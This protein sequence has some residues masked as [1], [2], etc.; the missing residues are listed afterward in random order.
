MS[1]E[2]ITTLPALQKALDA[3]AEERL[4]HKLG[5]KFSNFLLFH[6][7]RF[8][9]VTLG[10]LQKDHGNPAEQQRDLSTV[11]L[12]RLMEWVESSMFNYAIADYKKSQVTHLLNTLRA[13]QE[14]A[15]GQANDDDL[16]F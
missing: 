16:P 6:E 9:S 3:K 7:C 13:F 4:K 15:A 2:N 14:K 8:G 12:H 10:E 11:T 1:K 5:Q